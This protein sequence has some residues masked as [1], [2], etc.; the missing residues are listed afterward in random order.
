V[1]PVAF[2]LVS[3]RYALAALFGVC[4]LCAVGF[5]AHYLRHGGDHRPYAR[6]FFGIGAPLVPLA[7]LAAGGGVVGSGANP[8]WGIG[9]PVMIALLVGVPEAIAMGVFLA[10]STIAIAWY[11]PLELPPHVAAITSYNVIGT[12]ASMMVVV[13]WALQ[14]RRIVEGELAAER[15]RADRLLADV[16]PDVVA[17]RLK[18]GE[19]VA[20]HVDDATVLFADVV[21]FTTLVANLPADRL[22]PMLDELF[23]E[24]DA[25]VERHGL[26][27]I[28]TIGDCYMV[29]AGVPAPRADHLDATVTFALELVTLVRSRE[30]GGTRLD[31]RVG[32][33]SG[34]VLAGVIGRRRFLYDLWGDTVNT[35]SRMESSGVAGRVQVADSVAVRLAGRFALEERGVIEVKGKGPVRTSLVIAPGVVAPG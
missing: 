10:L 14:Q 12:G 20:S 18:R 6:L 22:L 17:E 9:W 11:V 19:I 25:L 35:A 23:R 16:L 8:V 30:F 7:T 34:P 13:V 2:G 4:D 28:K 5:F 3:G 1:F 33:H 29:A 15:A 26:E 32:I 27:K 24:V 21:G 31:V